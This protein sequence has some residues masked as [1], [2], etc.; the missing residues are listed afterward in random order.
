M[1]DPQGPSTAFSAQSPHHSLGGGGGGPPLLVEPVLPA[2]EPLLELL[3]APEPLLELLP[4]PEPLL[5]LLPA[6]EPLL[7]LPA[8]EPL[9]VLLPAPAPLEPLALDASAPASAEWKS[10]LDPQ[11]KITTDAAKKASLPVRCLMPM[12]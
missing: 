10:T 1:A 11:A 4:A 8:P 7:L 6:P 2:P 3:P 9:L 12:C 5:E